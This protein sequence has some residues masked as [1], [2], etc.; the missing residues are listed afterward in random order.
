[1][2]TGTP[3]EL[4]AWVAEVMATLTRDVLTLVAS[5]AYLVAISVA[6]LAFAGAAAWVVDAEPDWYLRTRYP[7]E[8]EHI[9]RRARA[10]LRP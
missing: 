2:N 9:V 7:L 3:D 1:M 10:E 6:L 4:D 5:C 8:Y